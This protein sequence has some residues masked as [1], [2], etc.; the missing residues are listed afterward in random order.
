[1]GGRRKT[2]RIKNQESR[3]KNQEKMRALSWVTGVDAKSSCQGGKMT[4]SAKRGDAEP[5]E[6]S[7]EF[8]WVGEEVI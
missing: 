3:I 7:A 6:E 2:S 8:L 4:V 5:A 1:V